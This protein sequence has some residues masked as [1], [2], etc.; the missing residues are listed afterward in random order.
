MNLQAPGGREGYL[1][2]LT[3]WN[4]AGMSRFQYVDGNAAVWL[5][6]LRIAML[7][8]YCR[9][10]DPVDR[11]PE[12]WRDVF[13][14]PVAERQLK[15]SAVE[16]ENSS[17]W[18]DVFTPFP[19]DVETQG[20]R[21]KRL[22]DQYD[23]LS[24]DYAWETMRAFARAAHILLGHLNAYANEGYL[25]TATQ[26]D[27]LRKLAAMVNYQPTPPASATTTIALELETDRGVVE[28]DRGLAIKYAPPQGGAPLVFETLKPVLCHPE[29][30]AVRAKGW[31][32]NKTKL[33]LNG[34]TNWNVPEKAELAQGDLA[35]ITDIS[36]ASGKAVSLKIV[37]HDKAAG[38]AGL[39]FDPSPVTAV[40]SQPETGDVV[41]RTEPDGVRL[42]LPRTKG[43]QV[44]VKIDNADSYSAGAIVEVIYS[45]SVKNR[46]TVLAVVVEAAKGLLILEP[47]ELFSG[48]VTVEAFTPFNTN[49]YGKLETPLGIKNLFFKGTSLAVGPIVPA[50]YGTPR[51]ESGIDIAET[52]TRP[53][54]A[55]GKA[56]A[57]YAGR[58]DTG[59]VVTTPSVGSGSSD[60]VVRFEGA[61]PK[62]L[63]QDTWYVARKV[64]TTVLTPLKVA[65]IRLE[66][67]VY[68]IEFNEVPPSDHDKTEFFGPMTRALHPI[69]YNRSMENPV[70]GGVTELKGLSG[71]ARDLVKVGNDVIM[72]Y[73]NADDRKSAHA[74]ITSIE[75]LDDDTLK[76]TLESDQAFN[77]WLAGWTKFHL[78]TVDISHGETKDPKILGSG[79]AEKK[80]QSFH[81]KITDVSFIPSNAAV[82]GVAPDMDVTVDGVKWEFRD[83]GDLTAEEQDAWSVALNEDDTLQIHFRR[84]L[85]TAT[86]NIAVSR[87]RVGVGAGGTGVP[88]WSMTK[89]MKKNRY[90]TGIVQ[91]FYT[92]GGANREPVSAIRDNAPSK[93]AANGRAVSLIDIDHLCKRHSSVWQAKAREVIGPGATNQVDVVIVP[94]NGGGINSTLEGDLVDF[95]QSRALPNTRVTISL[96]RSLM[97]QMHVKILVDISR[98]EKS[99]VKDA[100]EAGLKAEFALDNR[101]LGQPVYVAE[102]MAAM[103]RIKGVSS[104]TIIDF[105]S[106]PG[107][108]QPLHQAMISGSLAAIFPTEE[109]VAVITSIADVTVYVEVLV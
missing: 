59:K 16:F 101:S 106:K 100:V 87:H 56:F 53:D 6:E 63:K 99:D 22:L 74:V 103:E 33:N 25:G 10:I 4:R 51:K 98:Y 31:N 68:Y 36:G 66:S 92:A 84:R 83:F 60:N 91:P 48:D 37:V 52:H 86:N 47:G 20:K 64:G 29:L 82:T 96:Y 27:N 85:P 40:D 28:I 73:E 108:E 50:N 45:D 44:V 2:D 43:K 17:V 65:A 71:Q 89:P 11:T 93:L 1:F 26:W 75:T 90:V 42:G 61:P 72:A 49:A 109:Q 107:A 80:R 69:N 38:Q 79:D 7:G 24:S 88:P 81:F 54:Y 55:V 67:D 94:A 78:N 8:L 14:K 102:I 15:A 34:E 104:A 62:T 76:I 58:I 105:S 57:Q 3:R 95:V 30:N 5:E 46:Q 41:L 35:V 39:E 70:E 77:K 18:K 21:N 19:V 32:Y 12:K 23:T 9:G 97:L 13:M